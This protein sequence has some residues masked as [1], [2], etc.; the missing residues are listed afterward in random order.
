MDQLCV[1]SSD[2]RAHHR[3]TRGQVVLEY[4]LL[5]VVAVSISLLITK[6]MVNR[7]GSGF[8]VN[9]WGEIQKAIADDMNN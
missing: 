6:F 1:K 7:D 3:L 9:K 4:V 2:A 8:L 5:L